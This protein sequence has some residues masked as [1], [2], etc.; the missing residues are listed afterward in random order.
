MRRPF[1]A[2]NWK[3]N[4]EPGET[5][6]LARGIADL[7][8][9]FDA[10]DVAICPPFVYLDS[11][12]L[13][14]Q[15]SVVA[16]GAQNIFPEPK[17]AFTGEISAAMLSSLGCQCCIVGHSERRHIMGETDEFINKK[18]HA[19]VNAGLIAILCVGEQLF[20]REKGSTT[21]VIRSQF[22]AALAEISDMQMSLV[23]IAYEP[24]W[25]IGT[26]KTATPDQ[27]E[28]VHAHLRNL[29][30]DRF[31]SNLAEQT[32]I[33]YGG[34]VKPGNA[35]ELLAQ[36]NIDGALVGGASLVAEDFVGIVKA[37]PTA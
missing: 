19:V 23:T 28:E 8:Q 15:G 6:N 37:A 33:L 21:E 16:L 22:E 26:G 9:D 11:V 27:A 31:S 1:I 5:V 4:P 17:G 25:A 12:R 20:E 34:S 30:E 10:A 7:L 32:R 24:V 18:V 3:M 14:L 36:P 29:I 35:A 2:G 13:V